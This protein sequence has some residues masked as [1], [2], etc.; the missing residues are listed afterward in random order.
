MKYTT[1]LFF[2]CLMASHL[3]AQ[4]LQ[5][6]IK[7]PDAIYEAS[8]LY[9]QSKDSFWL[10]NDSGNPAELFC[11]NATGDLINKT[12]IPTKNRDWEDLTHD[13]Q[14]NIYIGEFGNNA[15]K[16]KKLKVYIWSAPNLDSIQYRYPDQTAF[17]PTPPFRNFDMEGF[18]WLNDELHLFSKNKASGVGNYYTKHYVLAAEK[19]KQTPVPKD[20]LNLKNRVVTA[21]A[22]SPDKKTVALLAYDYGL[23][24]GFIPKSKVS[25][26][27]LTN[28]EG[29]DFLKGQLREIKVRNFAIATQ[30]ECL[31]F[32][33]NK[34][35]L[36]GSEKTILYKQRLKRIDLK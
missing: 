11:V 1:F 20:S 9:I 14:G 24:W 23:V 17:P 2:I 22:I 30:Y 16:R 29:T 26:F 7:L 5:K 35:I 18:F 27:L 28:F 32:Y 15:N 36:I 33:D 21:A 8:G 19:G 3:E 12:S 4:E 31:D 13:E 25:I 10:L 6:I 34:T